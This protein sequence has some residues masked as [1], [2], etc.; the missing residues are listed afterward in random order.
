MKY[1]KEK[2]YQNKSMK[3]KAV[4][5]ETQTNWEK[6]AMPLSK[7]RAHKLLISGIKMMMC[8]GLK[9]E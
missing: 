3:P 8:L 7:M 4:L 6:Y 1:I 9:K 5:S 2:W